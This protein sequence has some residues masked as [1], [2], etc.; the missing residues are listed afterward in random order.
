M[1]LGLGVDRQ[2]FLERDREQLRLGL[3]GA[4]V[5]AL[6]QVGTIAAVLRGD[7]LTFDRVI[8]Q[9]TREGEQLQGGSDV[10]GGEVHVL[11]ET[12]RARLDLGLALERRDL[13]RQHLGDVGA[14]AAGLGHDVAPGVRV[15]AKDPAIIGGR[16]EEL[17]SHGRSHLVGGDV[18]LDRG[19]T[20][21][22]VEAFGDL[23]RGRVDSLR[24]GLLDVGTVTSDPYDDALADGDGGDLARVDL[25]EVVHELLQA[26]A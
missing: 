13:I 26:F 8:A 5:R 4:R 16:F 17:A 10:E 11:E 1:L 24:G 12:G 7:L 9:G 14:V 22:A 20:N 19:A 23:A 15:L 2:G 21:L 6:L 25:T 3:Q 18:V